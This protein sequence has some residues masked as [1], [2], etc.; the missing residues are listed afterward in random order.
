MV[1]IAAIP[2]FPVSH[3]WSYSPIIRTPSKDRD[4][5]TRSHTPLLSIIPL[6]QESNRRTGQ[7]CDHQ[8][9]HECRVG[10]VLPA[11][12]IEL[13]K[14]IKRSVPAVPFLAST[15]DNADFIQVEMVS[16][17]GVGAVGASK[18]DGN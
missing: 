15:V 16:I 2:T 11:P 8:E 17:G 6:I 1:A 10:R 3:Y 14:L 4:T 13:P 9:K 18:F 5:S 7:E 12:L